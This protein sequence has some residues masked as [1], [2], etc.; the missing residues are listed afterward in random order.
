ML[1]APNRPSVGVF[2]LK[3]TNMDT[4]KELIIASENGDIETVRQLLANGADANAMGPNSG[5]LHC[6]V[7]NGHREIVTLLLD[8]GSNP[9]TADNQSYY[10][11]HLAAAYKH[12]NIVR[13]LI[14]RGAKLDVA[15]SSGGTVLHVAAA[16]N[17]H[18]IM[19]I[20]QIKNMPLE[21]KDHEQKTALNVAASFGNYAIG[22]RLVD[23]RADVDTK[24]DFGF[25]PLLNVLLRLGQAKVEHWESEGT[26]SGV[27]VKYEIKN[28]CFR[29][30]KPYKGG[31]DEMGRVLSMMDQYDI[32]GYGWGPAK[33]RNYVECVYLAQYLI[34]K[35]ADVN[36]Q[37]NNG[38]T[39]MIMACSVGEPEVMTAL[40][41][42]GASFDTKNNEGIAALHFIA[43]SKRLDG[44]KAFLKL[45]PAQDINLG[46]ANGWT[47]GHYLADIGGH[48]EMAKIL[49]KAGL[50]T[51]IGST[52]DLGPLAAGI[53]AREV[54][55]HWKDAEIAKLLTP[56]KTK[57]KA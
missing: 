19:D 3:Q 35:G 17:F 22:W 50:D 48:P 29:Y 26:N 12:I 14:D 56:K 34:E 23:A 4:N 40:A 16:N 27:Y 47:A 51:A 11:I 39:P 25:T 44:L 54:A 52:G 55:E 21:A 37:G 38:N 7:A 41:K 9:N 53:T 32:S 1:I 36:A 49:V 57:S 2:Q 24:D 42:K 8:N 6:A 33:H 28:G 43:R 45:N 31:A 13:D 46:D 20:A 5:A 30:I 18:E 15:T 10:P